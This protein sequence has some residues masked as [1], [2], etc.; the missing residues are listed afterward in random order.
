[1]Q[2]TD[3]EI[4][5][6]CER[7]RAEGYKTALADLAEAMFN[8]FKALGY[9]MSKE[10]QVGKTVRDIAWTYGVQLNDEGIRI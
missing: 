7:A 8:Q 1:M 4:A 9:D 2:L 10:G 5:G 3:K 6:V